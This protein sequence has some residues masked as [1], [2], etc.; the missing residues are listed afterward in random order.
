MRWRVDALASDSALTLVGGAASCPGTT[1]TPTARRRLLRAA[2]A[3]RD[4]T[5]DLTMRTSGRTSVDAAEG[6]VRAFT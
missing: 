4:A 1:G 5:V 3:I 6:R 2:L